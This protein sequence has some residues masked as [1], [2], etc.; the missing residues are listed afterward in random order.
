MERLKQYGETNMT[1]RIRAGITVD[2]MRQSIEKVFKNL[3]DL[4]NHYGRE[5]TVDLAQ[6]VDALLVEAHEILSEFITDN[7]EET[8]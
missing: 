5:V 8:E 7:T 3:V 1:E 4:D 6:K 2:T